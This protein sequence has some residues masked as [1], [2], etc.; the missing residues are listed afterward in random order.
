MF[1]RLLVTK[2]C[3]TVLDNS[4]LA[5][6]AFYSAEK[7]GSKHNAGFTT[8]LPEIYHACSLNEVWLLLSIRLRK[9]MVLLAIVYIFIVY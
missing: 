9:A 6:F 4:D 8:G 1:D 2:N 5:N 7:Q 3:S